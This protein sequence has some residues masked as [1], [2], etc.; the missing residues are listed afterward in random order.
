MPT[1]GRPKNMVGD[2]DQGCEVSASCLV[3]PLSICKEDAPAWYHKNRRRAKDYRIM[4]AIVRDRLTVADAAARYKVTKRTV[5]R[6]IARVESAD[7]S[8]ADIEVFAT[9][10]SLE[11]ARVAA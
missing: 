8:V 1:L 3:C 7:I 6:I 10:A 11:P 5:H 9:L 4:N 2:Q